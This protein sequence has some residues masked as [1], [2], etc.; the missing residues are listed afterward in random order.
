MEIE[1]DNY[2]NEIIA[3]IQ[4]NPA[5]VNEIFE[6]FDSWTQI[7]LR[8]K[9]VANFHA[10]HKEIIISV[11]DLPKE[12][13]TIARCWCCGETLDKCL[14]LK[15]ESYTYVHAEI[16]PYIFERAQEAGMTYTDIDGRE[17]ILSCGMSYS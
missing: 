1:R 17:R 3:L 7:C 16:D 15:E 2:L 9:M 5:Q 14:T 12:L 4:T 11:D 6:D 10:N 8:Y 13:M